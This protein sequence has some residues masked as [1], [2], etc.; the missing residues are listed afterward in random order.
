MASEPATN[1]WP[2]DRNLAGMA[3][4][5]A[6]S[7]RTRR[8]KMLRGARHV[9]TGSSR[10]AAAPGPQQRGGD[11]RA[12]TRASGRPAGSYYLGRPA[13]RYLAAYARGKAQAADRRGMRAG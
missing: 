13:A 8:R 11:D 9:L 4:L 10:Q 5:D 2:W 3:A 6:E 1:G 7:R 12:A